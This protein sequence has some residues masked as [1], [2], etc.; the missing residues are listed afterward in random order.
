MSLK[1]DKLNIKTK[2]GK[3]SLSTLPSA[4]F[5]IFDIDSGDNPLVIPAKDL[6]ELIKNTSFAMGN[7]DWRH[8]L[9]GLFISIGER[10]DY[11]CLDRCS[12]VGR[13]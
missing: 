1:S 2:N 6:Q 3:Y 8:Y 12:Q 7:Q 10:Q 13:S 11:R 4:D 5:P 9:N